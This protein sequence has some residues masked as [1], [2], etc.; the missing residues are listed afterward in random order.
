MFW[1]PPCYLAK[2]LT[3]I[4]VL[5]F[6]SA[7]QSNSNHEV[8]VEVSLPVKPAIK[9]YQ[10]EPGSLRQNAE[11]I[12]RLF[13]WQPAQ[14]HARSDFKIQH[15][16]MLEARQIDQMLQDLL[17]PYPVRARLNELDRTVEFF[18]LRR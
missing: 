9:T 6:S 16:F 5:L 14:W 8:V 17:S 3:T 11:R 13:S 2:R 18:D 12:S 7:V 1:Q 10:V 4:T 15:T